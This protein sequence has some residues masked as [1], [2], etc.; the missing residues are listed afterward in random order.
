MK[1]N[2]TIVKT[3][4]LAT[5]II[6]YVAIHMLTTHCD[7]W[8]PL[9]FKPLIRRLC[10]GVAL[11]WTFSTLLGCVKTRQRWG[12]LLWLCL[13]SLQAHAIGSGWGANWLWRASSLQKEINKEDDANPA[14]RYTKL[15]RV[16]SSG[17]SG[18]RSFFDAAD[19]WHDILRRTCLL[20]CGN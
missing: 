15:P 8:S 12:R 17:I 13:W 20:H 5:A 11:W 1:S 3:S 10:V 16:T 6:P 9:A 14:Y 4:C 2:S 19:G 18:C 7:C